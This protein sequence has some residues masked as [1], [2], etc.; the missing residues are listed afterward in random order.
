MTRKEFPESARD[1]WWAQEQTAGNVKAVYENAENEPEE[2]ALSSIDV[3]VRPSRYDDVIEIRKEAW[4]FGRRDEGR[5]GWPL[6]MEVEWSRKMTFEEFRASEWWGPYLERT[7]SLNFD[8]SWMDSFQVDNDPVDGYVDVSM[9]LPEEK[10]VWWCSSEVPTGDSVEY[11]VYVCKDGTVG[12]TR[13][14]EKT[15]EMS[16]DEFL[17]AARFAERAHELGVSISDEGTITIEKE[18]DR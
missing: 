2:G 3:S 13:G 7:R 6:R 5:S 9:R 12:M 1:M 11:F 10:R 4:Y 15:I 16:I 14:K 17:D 18:I 8:S